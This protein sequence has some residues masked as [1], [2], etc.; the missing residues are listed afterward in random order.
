MGRRQPFRESGIP[1]IVMIVEWSHDAST[2]VSMMHLSSCNS[3][4]RANFFAKVL[5]SDCV[6]LKVE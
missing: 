4:K 3:E 5:F 1:L 6:H 2:H